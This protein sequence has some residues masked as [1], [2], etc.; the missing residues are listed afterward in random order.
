MKYA[1]ALT[2]AAI[3]FSCQSATAQTTVQ[4]HGKAQ[5]FS[6]TVSPSEVSINAWIDEAGFAHGVMIY[7]GGVTKGD[8][9]Q[10]GPADPWVLQ[11]YDIWTYDGRTVLVWA[12]VVHSVNPIDIGASLF[13]YFTDNS[14]TG[15][16]DEINFT[17]ITAGNITI[18]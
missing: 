1:L 5:L 6:P 18:R 2:C 11:V 13:L 12:T 10:G 8:F 7:T 14:G 16:P 3:A 17:P 9:P 15:Q 4:G